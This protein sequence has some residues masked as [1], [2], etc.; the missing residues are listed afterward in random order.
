MTSSA[1][2]NRDRYLASKKLEHL[3]VPN[4]TA[5]AN[6]V[7]NSCPLVGLSFESMVSRE[8]ILFEL[9]ELRKGLV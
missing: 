9:L 8:S 3:F 5:L 6:F 7:E 4:F 1:Q 2:Q